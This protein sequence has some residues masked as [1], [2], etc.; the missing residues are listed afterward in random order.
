MTW[1]LIPSL[2]RLDFFRTYF[3]TQLD[4]CLKNKNDVFFRHFLHLSGGLMAFACVSRWCRKCSR[5]HYSLLSAP[6]NWLFT[7]PPLKIGRPP[8]LD[9]ELLPEFCI[10][11]NERFSKIYDSVFKSVMISSTTR[12][13]WYIAIV[14]INTPKR[15]WTKATDNDDFCNMFLYFTYFTNIIGTIFCNLVF[16][17]GRVVDFLCLKVNKH[18]NI[19]FRYT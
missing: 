16:C 12:I 13:W 2:L 4:G 14:L 6:L 18:T 5:I 10:P 9:P 15:L 3:E 11:L 19:D 8:G 1:Y 7:S 17:N